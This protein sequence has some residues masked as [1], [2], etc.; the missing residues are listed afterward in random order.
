MRTAVVEREDVPIRIDEQD[1]AMAAVH[2]QADR[3]LSTPQ[4][5]RRVQIPKSRYS[6]APHPIG[7]RRS[8]I[9]EGCF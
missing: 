1:Q 3:W 5:C 7:V 4:G 6:S 2:K 9:Q 8:S